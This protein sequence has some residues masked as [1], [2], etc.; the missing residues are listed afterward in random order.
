[1]TINL[2]VDKEASRMAKVGKCIACGAHRI[3]KQ[4]M[5]KRCRNNG[6][7]KE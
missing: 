6:N 1:M 5:C 7:G 3:V 4:D 2:R